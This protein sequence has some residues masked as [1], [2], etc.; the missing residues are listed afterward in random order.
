MEVVKFWLTLS[1]S[2]RRGNGTTA[3]S[4]VPRLSR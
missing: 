2:G 4:L 1:C 3:I